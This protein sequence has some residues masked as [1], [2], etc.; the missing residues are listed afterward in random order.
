MKTWEY[1]TDPLFASTYQAVVVAAFGASALCALLSPLVVLK[2]LS[3]VGQGV[4][5]AAFAWIG[6]AALFGME[7]SSPWLEP[8]LLAFGVVVAWSIALLG[9]SRP[10]GLDSAIALVLVGCMAIGLVLLREAGVL[11][12]ATDRPA[13]PATE[14]ILF[15]S[16]VAVRWWQAIEAMVV[17]GL[18]A[19]VLWWWRRPVL[20]FAFDEPAA[21]SFGVRT[22]LMR[23]VLLAMLAIAVIVTMRLAGVVL[24][25]ALLVVPGSVA[26]RLSARWWTVVW[27]SL[28]AGVV[29]S[30]G[31][32]VL[33]F[34][35][36]W[37]PGPAIVGAL[38]AVLL[39]GEVW[40]LIVRTG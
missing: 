3:F 38:L 31:G 28:A 12:R 25:T 36:N 17:L 26:L 27:L 24:A 4:S 40:R 30:L 10:G 5:H 22:G 23:G 9:R 11:A 6:V 20:F 32:L 8:Q 37:P 18:I 14:S 19:G 29:G 13:P 2:K 7:L 39:L 15:G 34:E 1:L 16:I 21:R 35:F 33:S